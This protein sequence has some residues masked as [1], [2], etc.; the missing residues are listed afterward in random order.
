MHGPV[1]GQEGA[2]IT[3]ENHCPQAVSCRVAAQGQETPRTMAIAAGATETLD[4]DGRLICQYESGGR[5]QRY[6]LEPGRHYRFLAA[7]SGG[8]QLWLLSSQHM[9][10]DKIPSDPAAS[11]E[12][13]VLVAG[14]REYRGFYVNWQ[15]RAMRIV[16]AASQ[17]LDRQFGIRFKVVGYR[18]WEYKVAPRT[19]S[20]AFQLLHEVPPGDADL[21]IGFTLVPFDGARGEVRGLTQYFSQFVVI[22]DAWAPNGA[23]TRLVHELCHVF[24]AFHI[25]QADS[26]MQPAFEATPRTYVFG[27]PVHKAVALGKGVDLARGVESLT[28][29]SRDAL[30]ELFREHHHPIERLDEDPI[31]VGYRYQ[32]RRAELAGD[33]KRSQQMLEAAKQLPPLGPAPASAAPPSDH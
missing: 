16:A 8:V 26:V 9:P 28:A 23:T 31:T 15:D 1:S 22:P 19:A 27:E 2:R 21:V 4:A 20:Q 3:I 6:D 7:R 13:K 5:Q 11:R 33:T 25:A 14:G 18:T 10:V 32:A 29:E 30:R 24:G 17:R 12:I